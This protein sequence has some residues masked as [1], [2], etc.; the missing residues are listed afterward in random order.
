M[1]KQDYVYFENKVRFGFKR[2]KE[3]EIESEAFT[4]LGREPIN[5]NARVQGH[6][7]RKIFTMNNKKLSDIWKLIVSYNDMIQLVFMYA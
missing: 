4:L 5:E 7:R 1:V 6:V 3:G 2:L